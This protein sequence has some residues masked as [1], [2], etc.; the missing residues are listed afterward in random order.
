MKQA[1][2]GL[3][4]VLLIV[5]VVLVALWLFGFFNESKVPSPPDRVCIKWDQESDKCL[6]FR[7]PEE[8][9]TTF[10]KGL[11]RWE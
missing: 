2:F 9:K 3:L 11:L 8:N 6:E 7:N 1:K 4:G 10:M 5:L